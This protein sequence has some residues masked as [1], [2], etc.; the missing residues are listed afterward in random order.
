LQRAIRIKVMNVTTV[1]F[2]NRTGSIGIHI[3][4]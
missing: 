1:L 2:G 4:R 3:S